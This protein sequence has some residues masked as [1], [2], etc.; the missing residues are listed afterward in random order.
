[1]N[2]AAIM[3]SMSDVRKVL[4]ESKLYKSRN[5]SRKFTLSSSKFSSEFLQVSQ[6]KDY[7]LIYK[8]ALSK[9][10]YDVLLED[11]S[12][13]QFSCSATTVGNLDTSTIRYAFFENPRSYTTYVDFLHRYEMSYEDYGDGFVDYYEQEIAEARLKD[14]VTPIRYDYDHELYVPVH[15]PISHLHIGHNNDVRIPISKILTPVVFVLFVIKNVYRERWKVAYDTEVFRS[16]LRSAK[17]RCANV[18]EE[19]FVEQEQFSLYL[20]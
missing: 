9:M 18:N 3:D 15:H 2:I 6:K 12:I 11:D 14:S 4:V 8:T 1:M 13:F 20:L 17:G 10:D 5:K 16:Q 19:Y 7:E